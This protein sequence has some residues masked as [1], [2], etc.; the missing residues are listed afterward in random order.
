VIRTGDDSPDWKMQFRNYNGGTEGLKA[1]GRADTKKKQGL[2]SGGEKKT[3][4]LIC[5]GPGA[6]R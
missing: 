4:D 5:L 3:S 1:K 2:N 6:A